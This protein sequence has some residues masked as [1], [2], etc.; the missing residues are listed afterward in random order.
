MEIIAYKPPP[1]VWTGV[2]TA[3]DDDSPGNVITPEIARELRSD[4]YR[5]V[6]RY[7]RPDGVVLSNPKPGGDWQGCYSL[8]I[9]ES[10]WILEGGLGIVLVQFGIFGDANRGNDAGK[11]ALSCT[12]KLGIP[13]DVHHFADVE[14]SGP[15]SAGP[16]K[17]KAYIEAWAAG[18]NAGGGY[19]GLY[20]TGQVPLSAR[21]T[22]RLAGV[23]T[24]W[25]AAGPIPPS[26]APRGDCI[27]QRPP[28]RVAGMLVDVDY[29]RL[30]NRGDFPIL[31]ATPEIAADWH[32]EAIGALLSS[33][34]LIT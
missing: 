4:G 31:A 2:D 13:T 29:M 34:F 18:N 26:P 11:A 10:R 12:R 30:D 1:G 32:G 16:V 23:T 19:T 9:A 28:S 25:A 8:S 22:Y 27:Q 33:P 6:A 5:W 20:R 3:G 7:T 21:Q 24:Y 15:A 17:C 14:G